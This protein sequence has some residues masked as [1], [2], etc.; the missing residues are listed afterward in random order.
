MVV[1]VHGLHA[2]QNL[3]SGP[4]VHFWSASTA[5][6]LCIMVKLVAYAGGY[7]RPCSTLQFSHL[8]HLSVHATY[9]QVGIL[10]ILVPMPYIF[11]GSPGGGERC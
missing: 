5:A 4:D 6:G 8:S 2:L 10:Y 1:V 7:M 11:F 3:A 9:L